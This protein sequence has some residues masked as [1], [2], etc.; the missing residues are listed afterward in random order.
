MHYFVIKIQITSFKTTSKNFSVNILK[1]RT[2][3]QLGRTLILLG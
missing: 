1:G 2:E 3:V